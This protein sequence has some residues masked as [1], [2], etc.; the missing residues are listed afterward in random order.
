MES[1][2]ET[3]PSNGAVQEICHFGDSSRGCNLLKPIMPKGGLEPPETNVEST[4]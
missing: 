4:T 3:G 2:K 1:V